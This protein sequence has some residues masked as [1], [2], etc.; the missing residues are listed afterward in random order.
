MKNHLIYMAIVL[1]VGQILMRCNEKHDSQ[2]ESDISAPTTAEKVYEYLD[3]INAINAY[4]SGIQ[5]A[6][7]EAM[8]QGILKF[9]P[10][11]KTALIFEELMDS[12]NSRER[13]NTIFRLYGPLET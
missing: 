9:G 1:G 3:L 10:A 13:L 8:K 11:N 2:T 7:M 12:N 5:L 6:Y 4:T